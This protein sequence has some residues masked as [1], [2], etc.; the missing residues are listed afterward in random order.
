MAQ[1]V[2]KHLALFRLLVDTTEAQRLAIVKTCSPGQIRGLL[3]A[4]YN[5]LRG[6]C[7]VSDKVKKKLYYQRRI[8]RRLVSKDLTLQ[9]RQRLLVRHAALLPLLLNPV[10]E[11]LTKTE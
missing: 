1:R 11:L 4:I 9:Q 3:E 2:E 5:V 8:I 10:V 6:T 7:P